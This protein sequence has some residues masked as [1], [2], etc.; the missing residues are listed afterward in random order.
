MEMMGVE[1]LF[2]VVSLEKFGTEGSEP[3]AS[4]LA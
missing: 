4:I 1:L 2:K 3:D